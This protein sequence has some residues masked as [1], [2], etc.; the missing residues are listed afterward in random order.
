MIL[1]VDAG[2]S[3]LKWAELNSDTLETESVLAYDG[4]PPHEVIKHALERKI[5]RAERMII[6]SVLDDSF[7]ILTQEWTLREHDLAAEFIT[8]QKSA[9]GITVAYKVPEQLGVDRF[10]ALIAAHKH[11]AGDCIVVD[12]GTAITIDA[13]TAAGNHLGGVILPGIDLM[14]SSLT[15]CTQGIRDINKQAPELF[16][17]STSSAVSGGVYRTLIAAITRITHDMSQQFSGTVKLILCGGSAESLRPEL[18]D[19]MIFD[20]MLILKG[21]AVV[22][23]AKQ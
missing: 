2:N 5:S 6:C 20:P 1:L 21:L 14:T 3:R 8:T 22:A 9:Y 4:S 7:C 17:A 23:M 12:C 18:N 15:G 13:M 19:Q 10:V 11:Y 16:A